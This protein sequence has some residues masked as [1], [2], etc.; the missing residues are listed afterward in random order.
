MV[1]GPQVPFLVRE[2]G[3][4]MLCGT[5]KKQNKKIKTKRNK[6]CRYTKENALNT[7]SKQNKH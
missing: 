2:L 5:A 1:R 7:F 3:S 4:H 6:I